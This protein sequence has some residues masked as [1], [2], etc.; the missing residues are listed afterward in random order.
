VGK[1][2][3]A[4][5]SKPT[6]LKQPSTERPRRTRT[7]TLSGLWIEIY[8]AILQRKALTPDDLGSLDELTDRLLAFQAR[9]AEIARPFERAFTRGP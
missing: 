9:Y 6:V 4:G 1:V 7:S 3:E 8:F 5:R 2:F